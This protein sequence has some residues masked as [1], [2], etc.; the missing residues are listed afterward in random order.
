MVKK[1]KVKYHPVNFNDDSDDE[2]NESLSK[3]LGPPMK[4]PGTACA[5]FLRGCFI[6]CIILATAAALAAA[7]F[8]R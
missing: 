5:S 7:F 4:R 3:E 6:I 1:S 2:S 8:Y